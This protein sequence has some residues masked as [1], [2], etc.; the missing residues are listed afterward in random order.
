MKK[1]LGLCVAFM[2]S[3]GCV[4]D[5]A[6]KV[7]EEPAKPKVKEAVSEFKTLSEKFGYIIGMETGRSVKNLNADVNMDAL[8]RGVKDGL[9]GKEPA[10]TQEE[11]RAVI[12]EI[13]AQAAARAKEKMKEN[14]KVAGAFLEANKKKEGVVT[15]DSGL[16]YKILKKGDGP[17][18][19]IDGTVTV[20][21][22]GTL[23]DGTV[24]DSSY[25]RG[26]PATFPLK[27]VIAGWTEALQLMNVG[28]KCRLFIPPN[29]AYGDRGAGQVIGPNATLIFEVELLSIKPKAKPE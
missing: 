16:Q 12:K 21:Y 11:A 27:G 26:E 8:V 2:L 28:T 24:F 23:I 10:I 15:T 25:K 17:K 3:C 7:A 5:G 13:Y 1:I 14:A 20:H 9:A 4:A 22:R 6:E 18:P 19:T 29:L